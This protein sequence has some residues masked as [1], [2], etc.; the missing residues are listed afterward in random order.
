MVEPNDA[1]RPK[2]LCK[3]IRSCASVEAVDAEERDE[4]RIETRLRPPAQSIVSAGTNRFSMSR[5]PRFGS[6][7]R[8]HIGDKS[9]THDRKQTQ[10]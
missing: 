7:A 9:E 2:Y 1:G 6:I 10:F 3:S 8:S 5:S 4:R